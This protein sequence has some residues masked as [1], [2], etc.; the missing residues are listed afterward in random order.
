MKSQLIQQACL[1]R[2]PVKYRERTFIRRI[3]RRV[4]AKLPEIISV[5]RQ[6]HKV[7][8]PLES[9]LGQS[10]EAVVVDP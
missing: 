10:A 8:Q 5:E 1:D 6:A 3:V 9:S 2:E 7:G 4:P